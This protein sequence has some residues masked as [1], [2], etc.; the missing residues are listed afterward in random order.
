MSECLVET[1]LML[2]VDQDDRVLARDINDREPL[3]TKRDLRLLARNTGG[4]ELRSIRSRLSGH[5]CLNDAPSLPRDM[6]IKPQRFERKPG[7]HGAAPRSEIR[8][9]KPKIQRRLTRGLTVAPF[10]TTTLR[11]TPFDH[12]HVL[13]TVRLSYPTLR[14]AR[15]H[16]IRRVAKRR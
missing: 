5:T 2:R 9:G 6:R 15:L 12:Y 14:R 8:S 4:L 1:L 10:G 3:R 13:R 7:S 11:L 16:P